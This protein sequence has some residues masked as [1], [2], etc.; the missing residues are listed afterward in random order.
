MLAAPGASADTA[1][2]HFREAQKAARAGDTLRAYLL[3][4]RATAL[5]PHN[6]Q[7]AA[8]KDFLQ[9]RTPLGAAAADPQRTAF[10]GF[11]LVTIGELTPSELAEAR[12]AREPTR[13]R[14]TADRKSFN[15]R[16]DARTV[17]EQVAAAYGI[18]TSFG[19]DYQN[20]PQFAFRVDSLNWEEALRALEAVTNSFFIPLS[21]KA[22]LV[23]RDTPQRRAETAPNMAVAIPIPERMSVQEA[24]EI[25]TA[26]QQ[27]LEIRRAV[28]DPTRHLVFLRDQAS[29]ALAA[30]ALFFELSR[31]RAQVEIEVELLTATKTSALH[32]GLT[33][34]TSAPLVNFGTFLNHRATDLMGFTNF[35]TFG[36]GA[37]YLGLGV[38]SAR[39]LADVARSSAASILKSQLVTVDGQAASTHVGDRY[40]II[41]GG[42][43]GQTSGVGQVYAPPPTVNFQDLGLVLKVTPA[44]HQAGEVSL[45]LEAE[46]NVLG[47]DTANHIPVISRRQYT[48]KVRLKLGEAA[49]VAGLVKTSVGQ[50]STGLPGLPRLLRNN[51]VDREDTEVLLVLTPR[52]TSLPPWEQPSPA[53]WVGTESKPLTWF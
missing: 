30:R 25:V 43:Y 51:S 19:A 28:V 52:L 20:P 16:G 7:F 47:A 1:S 10:G 46:F 38:A 15:L 48:G 27:T 8:L 9:L 21:S 17:I 2:R 4:S 49:V 39:M 6:R 22:V 34:P 41:V 23:E 5:Q 13:L 40:P 36:H 12:E 44:V 45:E 33:T 37:T 24:Q 18:Q 50:A 26:V 11:D 31:L 29:K 42:Y 14:V 35:L 32:Y 3:A 53:L